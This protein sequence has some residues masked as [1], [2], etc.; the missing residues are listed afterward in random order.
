MNHP[1]T[2]SPRHPVRAARYGRMTP[3]TDQPRRTV[4]ALLIT[5][6]AGVVAGQILTVA[7]VYEPSAFRAPGES[8][9]RP[10]WPATRPEPTPTLRSN[11]RSRW[12]TVRALVE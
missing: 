11:D 12:A 3:T 6:A 8:G 4:Y 1:V 10:E 9:Q 7:R 2:P 5:A